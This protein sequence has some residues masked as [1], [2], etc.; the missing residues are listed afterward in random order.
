M[1]AREPIACRDECGNRQ[2]RRSERYLPALAN[3]RDERPFVRSEG[4]V[5]GG[6]RG[7]EDGRNFRAS[8]VS[9]N[10]DENARP[11]GP[12]RRDLHRPVPQALVL[13]ENDPPPLSRSCEPDAIFFIALEVVIVDLNSQAL[14]DKDTADWFNAQGSVD[15]E[16]STV[17]QLRSG[18]LLRPHLSPIGNPEQGQRPSRPPCTAR[19]SRRREFQ[20][21]R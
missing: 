13:G 8:Q 16:D 3:P 10:E 14:G 20:C 2:T 12:E 5:D 18:S 21:R 1:P 4:S 9:G 15:E 7:H 17:R 19:R 11:A 6:K